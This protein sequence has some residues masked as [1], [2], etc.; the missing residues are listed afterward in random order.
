MIK[1]NLITNS[2]KIEIN[3]DKNNEKNNKEIKNSIKK[4]K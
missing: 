1:E 4:K 2:E 3:E